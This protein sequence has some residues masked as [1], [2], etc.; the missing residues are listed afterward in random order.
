MQGL[1]VLVGRGLPLGELD[2]IGEA[3]HLAKRGVQF[4]LVAEDRLHRLQGLVRGLLGRG[5][6]ETLGYIG[7]QHVGQLGVV[8]LGLTLCPNLLLADAVELLERYLLGGTFGLFLLGGRIDVG[9]VANLAEQ[10]P[11]E[12]ANA[13]KQQGAEDPADISPPPD[14]RLLQ[15]LDVGDGNGGIQHER[16][17]EVQGDG[18][19]VGCVATRSEGQ[20]LDEE[21]AVLKR[22]E[23]ELLRVVL[24]LLVNGG[25]HA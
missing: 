23:H 16:L 11:Y 5:D 9:V 7:T 21:Q 17:H 8:L 14:R 18:L 13:G 15:G 25:V 6:T 1:L 3:E 22:G 10:P 12:E 19:A 2:E 24:A 20:R 4:A